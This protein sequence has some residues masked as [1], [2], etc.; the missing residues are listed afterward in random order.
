MK[1]IQLTE[2]EANQILAMLSELPIKHLGIVQAV[3]K[4]LVDKFSVVDSFSP[5]E[6]MCYDENSYKS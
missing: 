6:D 3:Q 5:K 1:S 2:D 4:I